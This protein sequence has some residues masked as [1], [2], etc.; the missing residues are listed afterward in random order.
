[1]PFALTLASLIC[2]LIVTLAGVTSNGLFLFKVDTQNLSISATDLTNLHSR[3]LHARFGGG[4]FSSVTAGPPSTNITAADL[5]LYDA[6]T[7]SL[8]NYCYIEGKVTTCEHAEFNWAGNATNITTTLTTL[9][10]KNGATFADSTLINTVNTLATII[11]WTE[12]VYIIAGVLAFVELVVGVFAF[13]SRVG[14]CCTFLVSG[15]STVAV[16]AAASLSTVSAA[17]VVGAVSALNK[18]GV[19][20]SFDTAF[21]AISWLAVAFSLAGSLFWL[22]SVCCCAP[23]HRE[24]RDRNRRSAA[25]DEKPYGGYQRVSD[26]FLPNTGHA[27]GQE[28]GY[29]PPTKQVDAQRYEPYSHTA[30]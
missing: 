26:P 6:Y 5:G 1:M 8:W 29:I 23:S 7:I 17:L 18:F 20:A 14:S 10:A 3:D 28:T 15:F 9:A 27:Q 24:R 11:K 4:P 19:S 30:V 2:I 21:L 13:C 22:F 12:I 16:I 25:D